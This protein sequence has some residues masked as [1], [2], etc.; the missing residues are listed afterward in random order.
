MKTHNDMEN[1]YLVLNEK[2]QDKIVYTVI[3]TT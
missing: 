3:S 1:A 2:K